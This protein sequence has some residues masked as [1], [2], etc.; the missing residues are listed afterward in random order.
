MTPEAALKSQDKGGQPTG[1]G[2]SCHNQNVNIFGM[3]IHLDTKW[4]D[5]FDK[6]LAEALQ[7]Y[8]GPGGMWWD[9]SR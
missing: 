5:P 4:N 2:V 7:R 9:T 8:L 6:K 3:G 1:C